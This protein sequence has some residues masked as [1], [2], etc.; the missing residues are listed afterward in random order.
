MKQKIE[1]VMNRACS[2]TA[3]TDIQPPKIGRAAPSP[4]LHKAL[5]LA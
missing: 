1:C 5:R 4:D 3:P 2:T